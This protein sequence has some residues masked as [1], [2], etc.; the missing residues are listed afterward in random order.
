MRYEE[1]ITQLESLK[2]ESKY[3]NDNHPDDE[4]WQR[5]IIA[6]NM[7]IRAIEKKRIN[8]RKLT[9]LF[10]FITIVASFFLISIKVDALYMGK[11]IPAQALILT[12]PALAYMIIAADVYKRF[13]KEG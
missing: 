12:I 6:L 2:A 9:Q 1:V 11:I 4:V 7:A 10:I 13:G 5:D 8:V 3:M